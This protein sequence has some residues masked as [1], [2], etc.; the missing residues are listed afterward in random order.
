MCFFKVK[1]NYFLPIKE[2]TNI[3]RKISYLLVVFRNVLDVEN[4]HSKGLANVVV[5][6]HDNDKNESKVEGF[7]QIF[8]IEKNYRR[9]K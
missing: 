3:H 9:L 5:P 4:P 6:E 8:C 7:K 2:E 1:L